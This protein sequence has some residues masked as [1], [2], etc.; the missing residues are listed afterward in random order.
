MYYIHACIISCQNSKFTKILP[1]VIQMSWCHNNNN[2][3]N[4]LLWSHTLAIISRDV[5]I[6]KECD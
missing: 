4:C 2:N 1:L 3:V 5:M 6:R